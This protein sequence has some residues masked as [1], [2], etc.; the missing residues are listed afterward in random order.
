[1][2]TR[3]YFWILIFGIV[4]S[5]NIATYAQEE[6]IYDSRGRR[7]PFVPLLGVTSSAMGS[8]DDVM[9]ID[10]VNLQGIAS[11]SQGKKAAIINGE[12]IREGQTI[13]RVTLKKI[14]HEK[15]ELMIDDEEYEINIY[16]KTTEQKGG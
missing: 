1:M 9:G 3:L 11:D 4:F 6:Y 7:D 8:L 12:M 2:R 14:L 16:D 5:T 10:D 15:I 13:G